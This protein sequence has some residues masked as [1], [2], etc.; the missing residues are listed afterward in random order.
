MSQFI[1]AARSTAALEAIRNKAKRG[2]AITTDELN[3]ILA[4]ID[5]N[6]EMQVPEHKEDA[7]KASTEDQA[8]ISKLEQEAKQFTSGNRN[9]KKGE[10]N[11]NMRKQK[12][13]VFRPIL[14]GIQLQPQTEPVY[15]MH[16]IPVFNTKGDE[17]IAVRGQMGNIEVAKAS[18]FRTIPNLEY[19]TIDHEDAGVKARCLSMYLR[20]VTEADK[21][22]GKPEDEW[23]IAAGNIKKSDCVMG[24]LPKKDWDAFFG[25]DVRAINLWKVILPIMTPT[26]VVITEEFSNIKTMRFRILD[27]MVTPGGYPAHDGD[28]I[29]KVWHEFYRH[30]DLD[31][32]GVPKPGAKV[33]KV[34]RNWQVRASGLDVNGKIMPAIKAKVYA[35]D[36]AYKELCTEFGYDP[37]TQDAFITKDNLKTLK[38]LWKQGDILEIPITNLRN[39]KNKMKDWSSSMGAQCVANSDHQRTRE[40][41]NGHGIIGK[42]DII[43]GSAEL[44]LNQ[45]VAVMESDQE[46]SWDDALSMPVKCMF[47]RYSDGDW[48]APRMFKDQF[49]IRNESFYRDHG[50]KVQ[51]DKDGYYIQGDGSLDVMENADEAKTGT[52]QYYVYLPKTAKFIDKIKVGDKIDLGRD[53]NVGPSN[54][55]TYVV[56]GYNESHDAMVMSWQSIYA[57]YGDVDGDTVKYE[58]LIANTSDRVFQCLRRPAPGPQKEKPAPT[59]FKSMDAYLY[60]HEGVGLSVLKSAADTGSLDLTTRHIIEE[61]MYAGI[62]IS[63]DEL[64]EL[65]QLRQD[66]IDGLKHT[67]AGV[68]LE[69]KEEIIKKYGVN[70][71]MSKIKD[72]PITYRLLR[73]DAGKPY[74][75]EVKRF[76]ERIKLIN[77]AQPHATHPYFD[78]FMQLKGIKTI[79]KGADITDSEWLFKACNN[80]LHEAQENHKSNSYTFKFADVVVLGKW[81]NDHYKSEVQKYLRMDD[82]ARKEAFTL[83]KEYQRSVVKQKCM[84]LFSS[85]TSDMAVKYQRQVTMFLGTKGFG[86]GVKTE[87]TREGDETFVSYGKTGGAIWNMMEEHTLFLAEIINK[88]AVQ[89]GEFPGMNPFM[90]KIKAALARNREKATEKA[91][92][93]AAHAIE[94]ME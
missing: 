68:S 73:K 39:V 74:F 43:K 35:D 58:T 56:A 52:L 37:D 53:P 36:K 9:P 3:Q 77:E 5:N 23:R 90:E 4:D 27:A 20:K 13:D 12:K 47:S 65:S 33:K 29:T 42:A 67:D 60:E 51:I 61:R 2:E 84:E 28:I 85:D 76:E 59:T 41:L 72:A 94:N 34:N 24:I 63:V 88:R 11:M 16:I 6:P 83:L 1:N 82:D 79:L 8:I 71:K 49:Y 46:A 44:R 62:P 92:T 50:I 75:N 57:M 78:F 93:K 54:L 87:F 26:S 45:I 18:A 17:V 48:F 19:V 21:A 70:G 55:M 14:G 25:C 7:M 40:V 31:K 89:R 86:R 91:L 32:N 30:S 80:L 69:A 81:L 15:G 66:A 38:W 22:K 10:H 64:M